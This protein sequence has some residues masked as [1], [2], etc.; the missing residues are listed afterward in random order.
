MVQRVNFSYHSPRIIIPMNWGTSGTVWVGAGGGTNPFSVFGTDP[1]SNNFPIWYATG[2]A[3]IDGKCTIAVTGGFTAPLTLT[4]WEY[5]R[6]TKGWIKIG[7]NA[8]EYNKI[9]DDTYALGSFD[10]SENA[11]VLIQSSAAVT[12]IAA[13]DA[14]LDATTV[15]FLQEGF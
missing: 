6:A 1:N 2:R 8:N 13:M 3:G 7:A 12:G 10:V 11:Y 15:G 4:A 5:N 9:Y 14:M